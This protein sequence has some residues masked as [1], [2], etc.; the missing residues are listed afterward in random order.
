M[1]HS[2]LCIDAQVLEDVIKD[3]F[4]H[5]EMRDYVPVEL[6]SQL[7]PHCLDIHNIVANLSHRCW[8]VSVLLITIP[9]RLGQQIPED[10]SG[11][12]I[13]AP[14]RTTAVRAI[15]DYHGVFGLP[16]GSLVLVYNVRSRF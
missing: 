15:I 12:F 9:P 16:Q 7:E 1:I 14:T 5:L 6:C 3:L 11:S 4:L 8:L 2:T 13:P 10:Q